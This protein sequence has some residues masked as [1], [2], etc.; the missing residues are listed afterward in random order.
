M[1]LEEIT[2]LAGVSGDEKNI[3]EYIKN[4]IKDRVDELRIDS[5]GNLIA[6]KKGSNSKFKL[7]L[8]AHMDEVG[9]IVKSIND[10][11]TIKFLTIGGFDQRVLFGKK[12]L[13]GKEKI[14]GV[15][16]V[17]PIHLQ[18]NTAKRKNFSSENLFIDIGADS[19]EECQ[20]IINPGDYISFQNNFQKF[21]DGLIAAKA[22]DDRVGC[23]LLIELINQIETIDFDLVICFTVQEEIGTRGAEIAAYAESPDIAI[24]I[25]GTTASDVPDVKE[26]NYS[27]RIGQGSVISLLDGASYSNKKLV[28]FIIETAKDNQLKYQIKNTITGG[29]DAGKIQRSRSGVKTAVISLPVRYIHSPVSVIKEEDYENTAK[30]IKAIITKISSFSDK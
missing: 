2:N 26:H 4:K 12:V 20:N 7:M 10:D 15:I 24:V 8:A 17:T 22:L 14:P 28:D 11:G 5:M 13:V 18:T 30:L 23:V 29:N 25:E 27:S 16:G 1:I 19:K 9:F 21:G 6:K 3:T